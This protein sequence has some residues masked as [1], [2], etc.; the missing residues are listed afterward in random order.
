MIKK[1]ILS[2]N[3]KIFLIASLFFC[4]LTLLRFTWIDLINVPEG[5]PAKQ[6]TID[7]R[8]INTSNDFKIKLQGEWELYPNTLL[9]SENLSS[10]NGHR[11]FSSQLESWNK[12]IKKQGDVHFGSYRLTILKYHEKPQLYALQ[13][14]K[15]CLRMSYILMGSLSAV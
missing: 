8:A 12:Y 13:Y 10:Q 1:K 2:K 5:V 7:L 9:I 14:L 4:L 3:L 15:D 6:G 11:T